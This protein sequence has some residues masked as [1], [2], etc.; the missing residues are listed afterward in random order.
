MKISVLYQEADI[1]KRKMKYITYLS[2]SFFFSI[3]W[4]WKLY[5]TTV[6]HFIKQSWTKAS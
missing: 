3:L 5:K 4:H 6:T 1:N 2:F